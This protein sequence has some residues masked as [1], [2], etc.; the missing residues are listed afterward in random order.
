MR[1]N[2]SGCCCKIDENDNIVSLGQLY[3]ENNRQI[4]LNFIKKIGENSEDLNP[5]IAS[6]VS[7]NFWDLI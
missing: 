3:V 1:T 5:D 2:K 4:L 7:K 6:A